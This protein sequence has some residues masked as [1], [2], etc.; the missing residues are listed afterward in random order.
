MEDQRPAGA[1]GSAGELAMD[2]A[3]RWSEPETKDQRVTFLQLA[4]NFAAGP[5][6]RTQHGFTLRSLSAPFD[7]CKPGTLLLPPSLSSFRDASQLFFFQ[8]KGHCNQWPFCVVAAAPDGARAAVQPGRV[9]AKLG[10]C[11]NLSSRRPR[12]GWAVRQ[13]ISGKRNSSQPSA[14]PTAMSARLGWMPPK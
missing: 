8:Q 13:S 10:R 1:Q 14:Q 3:G 6:S 7:D 9:S 4:W 2:V 5:H 11:I 12:L